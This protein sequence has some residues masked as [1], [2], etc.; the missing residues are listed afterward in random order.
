MGS[1]HIRLQQGSRVLDWLLLPRSARI[2]DSNTILAF[3]VGIKKLIGL[4]IKS[5]SFA[6]ELLKFLKSGDAAKIGPLYDLIAPWRDHNVVSLSLYSGVWPLLE[7]NKSGSSLGPFSSTPYRKQ[8]DGYD[9][10]TKGWTVGWLLTGDAKLGKPNNEQPTQ[11]GQ[12]GDDWWGFY[13]DALAFT[14]IFMLPH[15]GSA[16][17]LPLDEPKLVSR[18]KA[19]N[20]YATAKGKSKKHPAEKVRLYFPNL[21]VVTENQA[22]ELFDWVVRRTQ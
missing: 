16:A 3:G 19:M 18:L 20:L 6:E 15:H 13:N 7:R 22:D 14:R 5:S 4:D 17:N 11:A 21:Y 8:S 2:V 10:A 9:L 1:T 12:V